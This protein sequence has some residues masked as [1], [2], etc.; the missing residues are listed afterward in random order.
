M[1]WIVEP[2]LI[3]VNTWDIY[4]AAQIVPLN[5]FLDRRGD[6]SK[7]FAVDSATN[8]DLNLP[9]GSEDLEQERLVVAH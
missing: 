5:S 4:A 9:L 3:A 2:A 1:I 8:R 7:Q 6:E